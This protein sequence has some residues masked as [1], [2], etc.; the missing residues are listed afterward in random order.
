DD[1]VAVSNPESNVVEAQ[2]QN[3][4]A[5]S[6]TRAEEVG[7]RFIPGKEILSITFDEDNE[8]RIDLAGHI[9]SPIFLASQL[10]WQTFSGNTNI[11]AS[12]SGTL[13]V[14]RPAPDWNGN[15]TLSLIVMDP[16]RNMFQTN[17]TVVVRP[18]NDPPVLVPFPEFNMRQGD[19][20]RFNP[21]NHFVD[22]EGG[23]TF[24]VVD[25]E[26]IRARRDPST[27]EVYIDPATGEIELLVDWCWYGTEQIMLM[28]DDHGLYRL[29]TT[30]TIN[31][32]PVW[33]PV[34]YADMKLNPQEKEMRIQA[35]KL[36][37]SG[38][39]I[40]EIRVDCGDPN[41]MVEITEDNTIIIRTTEGWTGS[42]MIDVKVMSA[43]GQFSYIQ[44][45]F[46]VSETV[47]PLMAWLVNYAM[48]MVF[49]GVF[50]SGRMY[51]NYRLS[52]MPSPVDLR[53]Y[54]HYRLLGNG[55]LQR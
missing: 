54:R 50:I 29:E 7:P 55:T 9:E 41:I 24:Q 4:N 19:T 21:A 52:D 16:D 13:L 6:E 15:A 28:A 20:I 49:A 47:R 26:Y 30:I 33:I 53:G 10:S 17:I 37:D 12:I 48:G 39:A 11:V 2:P 22:K 40:K 14:L 31:V 35:S 36:V 46:V 8:A 43:G 3:T 51:R 25:G 18:V 45:P 42:A 5:T 38:V 23:L 34:T 27:G 1:N 44:V 32:E